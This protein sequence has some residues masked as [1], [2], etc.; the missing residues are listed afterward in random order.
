MFSTLIKA[1]IPA[2]DQ[3][4]KQDVSLQYSGTYISGTNSSMKLSADD[5]GLLVSN[6]SINRVDV[7][8]ALASNAGEVSTSI[9]PYPVGIRSGNQTSWRAVY[10]TSSVEELAEFDSELFFPQ[11]SCQTW[12]GIDT[13]KYGLQ[14]LDHF[15][16][17]TDENG[18]AVAIEPRAWRAKLMREE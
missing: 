15:I 12:F 1:L 10:A 6:L 11:G 7:A 2:V 3:V 8:A 9:R 18:K 16:I 14:A 17:T 13:Q 4:A 5:G